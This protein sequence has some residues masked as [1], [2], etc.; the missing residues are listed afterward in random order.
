MQI[1]ADL[2]EDN[3]ETKIPLLELPRARVRRLKEQG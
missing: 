3:R 2:I 1:V